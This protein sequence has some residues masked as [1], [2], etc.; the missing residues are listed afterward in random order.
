MNEWLTVIS[1]P[2]DSMQVNLS[3]PSLEC[4]LPIALICGICVLATVIWALAT[5]KYIWSQSRHP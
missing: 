2:V 1:E 3:V 4:L 5:G